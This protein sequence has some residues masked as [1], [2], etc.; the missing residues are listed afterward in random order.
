MRFMMH[1]VL[2]VEKFNEALRNGS[3]AKTMA[4][5]LEQTK[6]EAAYFTSKDGKRGGYLVVDIDNVAKI[7]ALAEPWFL[8]FNATVEFMP[9]MLP[10]DLQQAD[11]DSIRKK[12]A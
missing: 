10:Q 8:N 4:T 3:A 2:P 6:P 12:W 9:V 11:L 7:P 5:I 1:I